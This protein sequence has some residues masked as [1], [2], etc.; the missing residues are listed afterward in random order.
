MSESEEP[1]MFQK[2]PSVKNDLTKNY[3]LIEEKVFVYKIV[4]YA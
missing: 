3:M 4:A 1:N 2:W